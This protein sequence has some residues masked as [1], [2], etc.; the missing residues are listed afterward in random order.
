L[1]IG[2]QLSGDEAEAPPAQAMAAHHRATQI[3]GYVTNS[4]VAAGAPPR[5]IVDAVAQGEIATAAV[6][7]PLAGY[8]AAD[9]RVPLI[10]TPIAPDRGVTFVFD[11]AMLTRGDDAAL[12]DA[13]NRAL[14][15]E[16]RPLREILRA[17]HVP[18]LPMPAASGAV[19]AR[20]RP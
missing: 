5:R 20:V 10:L 6:W 16:R 14:D 18:L 8:Y 3:R 7:G 11:I 4:L 17:Y 12:L 1:T 15:T 9:Q 13:L 19:P 2:V